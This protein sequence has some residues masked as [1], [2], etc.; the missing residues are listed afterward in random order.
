MITEETHTFKSAWT[1]RCAQSLVFELDSEWKG[2]GVTLT[3][4]RCVALGEN[5]ASARLD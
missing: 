2:L 5:V 3:L 4:M 1:R